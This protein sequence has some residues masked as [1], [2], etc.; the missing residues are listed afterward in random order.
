MR[1]T[2]IICTLGPATDVDGVL[3]DMVKAGMNVA[4]F[5]FSHGSHEEH[6]SRMDLVKSV[7]KELGMPVGIMLDTKGPEIRTKT[8]KDGKIEIVEGQ[9][10]TLTTRDIEG[11]NTIVSIS[12]EGLPNDVT[13]GTTILIDDGLIAFK[14][15]K[16][17]GTEI[18]CRALNGGPLSN[19]KS[20]NVP[21][22]KLNMPY[23]SEKDRSDVIFGCSQGIDF[24]AAS[25]C[26]SAQDMRDLKA[27]LKEQGCEDVEIIAK[28]ENMEGVNN[29]DE[30]LDEVNGIM[31]ARGDLGV[32]VPFEELPAI[33]KNLIKKCISRGRRV[34]TAT[35]MLESMAKNP[36]PTRAEVSDVA[37]A[38][39]DGTSAIMLS[40]ETS[41]GKYPVE[42]VA[43]MSSI[44]E[45]A[46][47]NI[48]YDR[49]RITRP[50]F[51]DMELGGERTTNAISHA[52]CTTA[53]D[54]DAKC[55]VAFTES[56]STARAVSCHRPGKIIVGAT[57]S[58]KTYNRLTMSWG[59]IPCMVKRPES[60][61]ALYVQALNAAVRTAGVKA[62]DTIIITAGMPVGHVNYTNTMR[63]MKVTEESINIAIEE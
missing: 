51:M 17:E 3:K 30:I 12:Y 6:K 39:Y 13:E 5:N 62:D 55:I 38:V 45:N 47:A 63:A 22:I 28:I 50:E 11:D 37:N 31:V 40:G 21:G 57:P 42:T 61:S 26:R 2:K 59:I 19:R 48:H 46:E 15:E 60:G 35:Q 41:V 10:F 20:V 44:A 53:A 52:V 29:I 14:V 1:R 36:R 43:A 24:I 7:R 25:F 4:R 49:R 33:Q 58:E 56:G 18:V 9:Q 34:V 16:V 32:E 54:L 23:I 8:Y 27:I